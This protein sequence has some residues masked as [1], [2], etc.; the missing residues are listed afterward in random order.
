MNVTQDILVQV[1]IAAEKTKHGVSPENGKEL[2]CA[3]LKMP[4]IRLKGIMALPPI[5]EN[6]ETT[7]NNFK[8]LYKKQKNKPSLYNFADLVKLTEEQRKWVS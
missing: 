8:K 4:N 6:F 2:I 3:I 5:T 1:N 7:R